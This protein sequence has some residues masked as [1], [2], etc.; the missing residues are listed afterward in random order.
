MVPVVVI[1]LVVYPRVAEP[2][3][4]DVRRQEEEPRECFEYSRAVV[5]LRPFLEHALVAIKLRVTLSVKTDKF[6]S[7]CDGLL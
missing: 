6:L 2:L 3:E 5:V 7:V 1:D 4:V